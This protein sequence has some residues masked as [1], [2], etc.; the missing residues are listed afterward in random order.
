[1]F[2]ESLVKKTG[3]DK[4]EGSWFEKWWNKDLSANTVPVG[5]RTNKATD[6]TTGNDLGVQ[7]SINDLVFQ[8]LGSMENRADFVLC[9]SQINTFKMRT[10]MKHNYMDLNKFE[11]LLKDFKEGSMHSNDV[12]SV[13]RTVCQPHACSYMC[14]YA[15]VYAFSRY[16]V[17]LAT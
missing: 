6:L 4:V 17:S 8:A 9:D 11:N 1:M 13:F 16:S 12:L 15:N 3:A 5:I 14:H 2:I 10:W 7:A